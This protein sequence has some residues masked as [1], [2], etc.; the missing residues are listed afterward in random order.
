MAGQR[1]GRRHPRPPPG[2]G[3][4]RDDDLRLHRGRPPARLALAGDRH[5]LL[6]DRH[7]PGPGRVRALGRAQ[8]RLLG[9]GGAQVD[10]R[11]D[12]RRLRSP[13]SCW[14]A[15][16]PGSTLADEVE[17]AVFAGVGA[18]GLVGIAIALVNAA[19]EKFWMALGVAVFWPVGVVAGV[20]AGE[21]ALALGAALLPRRRKRSAPR[22]ATGR[23]GEAAPEPGSGPAGLGARP[24]PD[25]P[26]AARSRRRSRR[27]RRRPGSPAGRR[28]CRRAGRRRAP[29]ITATAGWI[30]TAF[31]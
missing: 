14:S 28:G 21:A 15:S 24:R 12:H 31:L 7:G 22:S 8:G 11:D 19:K 10:R 13:G 16:A 30:W 18:F 4:L 3:D 25:R 26:A 5:R 1:R 20:P 9:E 17:N 6:R 23:R 2:L 29:T 27:A